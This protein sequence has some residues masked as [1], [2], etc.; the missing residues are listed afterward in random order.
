[1]PERFIRD[2]HGRLRSLDSIRR[3][4]EHKR[5]TTPSTPTR[6]CSECGRVFDLSDETDAAEW[7]FGHDCED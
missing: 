5:L 1:M 6:T 3:T 2:R 7:S 4:A